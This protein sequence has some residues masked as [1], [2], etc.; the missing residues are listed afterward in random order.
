M[1][2][3]VIKLHKKKGKEK[4]YNNTQ[5]ENNPTHK[6]KHWGFVIRK[7]DYNYNWSYRIYS[8]NRPGCLL[9]FWT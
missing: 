4:K 2:K 3:G 8:I 7:K 5:K 6:L 1:N 9:K